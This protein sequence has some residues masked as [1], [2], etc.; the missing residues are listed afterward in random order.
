MI[1]KLS[2]ENLVN[3]DNGFE[4]FCDISLETL[5]KHAP[6]K[7]KHTQGNQ[8]PFFNKDL[9]KVI[10]TRTKYAIFSSKIGVRKIKYVTQNGE[11]FVFLFQEKTK[12]RYYENLNQ[13]SVVIVT[14]NNIVWK[15][16]RGYC[17]CYCK[18]FSLVP[19]SKECTKNFFTEE[20]STL[21]VP[22]KIK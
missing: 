4:S 12:K 5:N 2:N 13:K 15:L 9:S 22:R 3:N 8:M 11:I 16:V 21:F 18:T 6:Y 20:C 19:D 7:K 10:I 1:K 17:L 14:R